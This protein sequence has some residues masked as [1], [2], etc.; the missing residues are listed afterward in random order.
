MNMSV[1]LTF[2]DF[3]KAVQQCRRQFFTSVTPVPL[4]LDL[5]AKEIFIPLCGI[6]KDLGMQHA[7][8]LS[9]QRRQTSEKGDLWP[10]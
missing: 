7:G 5:V 6:Y 2:N 1:L 8:V 3:Q 9:F 4:Y 10:Q